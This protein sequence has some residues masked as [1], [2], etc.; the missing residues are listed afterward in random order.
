MSKT[1]DK[2]QVIRKVSRLTG[3]NPHVIRI[4]E[5]RYGAVV[6]ERTQTNRRV[7]TEEDIERLQL[8]GYLTREGR[9][10]GQVA[11]LSLAELKGLV[12]N[13]EKGRKIENSLTGSAPELIQSCLQAIEQL[14]L[15]ELDIQLAKATVFMSPVIIIQNLVI[16]LLQE[17]ESRVRQ[18]KLRVAHER[19]AYATLRPF[20]ANFMKSYEVPEVAPSLLAATLSGQSHEFG[21]LYLTC[22]A[23]A[24]GF[25]ATY[26]GSNLP[27][28]EIAYAA[29]QLA[30][31][32][33]GLSFNQLRNDPRL[34]G[35][36]QNLR[37]LLPPSC[38]ILA[39]GPGL[40]AY[41]G[42]MEKI[43]ALAAEDFSR[44]MATLQG[45]RG[46]LSH[47]S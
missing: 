7:Y 45:L 23:A 20:L 19:F 37:R 31:D 13:L 1:K 17:V 9:R 10:I 38:Q 12:E 30:V 35:E 40:T 34:F 18:G 36:M 16:P 46:Q 8:L 29:H 27:A 39:V 14:K 32:A 43:G 42:T 28:E 25:K 47:S 33:V 41:Q 15:Q 6:P 24:S 26:L 3:L 44:I 22:A 2:D 4:W 5:K 11:R 21:A